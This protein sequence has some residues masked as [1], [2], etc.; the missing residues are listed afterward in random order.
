MTSCFSLM[1]WA[2]KKPTCP[3]S[4]FLSF[5]GVLKPDFWGVKTFM[6]SMFNDFWG[7]GLT[8]PHE[9]YAPFLVYNKHPQ[10]KQME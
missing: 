5:L 6:Y 7:R 4:R 3:V 10:K 1:S 8:A 2:K 9:K